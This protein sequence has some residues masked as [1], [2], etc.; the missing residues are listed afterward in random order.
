ML[1]IDIAA[2]LQIFSSGNDILIL[3]RAA[4]GSPRGFAER[5]AMAN[6]ATIIQRQNDVSAADEERMP[7]VGI[8]VIV[9]PVPPVH[10]LTYRPPRTN[11]P[12]LP[13]P[14]PFHSPPL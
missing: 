8:W 6:S 3:R 10:N 7:G 14:V 11:N 12:P 1:C 9:H 2:A 13:P 5:A 4:S